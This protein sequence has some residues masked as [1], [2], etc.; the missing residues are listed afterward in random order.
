MPV[1]TV[2]HLGWAAVLSLVAASAAAQP[3]SATLNGYDLVKVGNPGNDGQTRTYATGGTLEFGS[4]ATDFW[5]GK[6]SVT[7]GQYA[8]FLNAVAKSDPRGL[9]SASMETDDRISGIARD[10][11]DGS[12]VYSVMEPKGTNPV[13]AQS[14]A[15][16]PITYVSWFDAARFANW[17]SNGKPTATG[18]AALALIDNGAYDLKTGTSGNSPLKNPT[19]PFTNAAPTFYI[20]TENEWYKAA[21]YSPLL[22]SGSGGYYLYGAGSSSAPGNGYNTTTLAPLANKGFANQANYRF[23]NS[24]YALTSGTTDPGADGGQNMLTDVGA[25]TN[26]F[27]FYGAFDMSGNVYQLVDTGVV[28]SSRITRGGGWGASPSFISGTTRTSTT[29]TNESV[30]TG[31]R[32]ASPVPEPATLGLALGGGVSVCGWWVLKRRGRRPER[33][34]AR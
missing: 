16:R 6:N 33:S 32:L 26:S 27:S 28:S 4:V 19:N 5:I 8:E 10:G 14:A 11:V 20:P 2:L 31:F 1:K 23:S 21:Y 25:F 17:M 24:R 12:Y 9:W 30:F 29:T 22:N 15:N 7:I 13:G 34:S 18:T 3:I